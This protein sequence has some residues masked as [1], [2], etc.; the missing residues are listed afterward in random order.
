MLGRPVSILI[1]NA[2]HFSATDWQHLDAATLDR[3]LP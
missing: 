1:N 2:A 3:H